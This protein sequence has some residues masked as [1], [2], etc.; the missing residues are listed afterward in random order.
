[1][2]SVIWVLAGLGLFVF[3]ALMAGGILTLAWILAGYGPPPWMHDPSV[4]IP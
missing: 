1:V 2:R 4:G 3:A